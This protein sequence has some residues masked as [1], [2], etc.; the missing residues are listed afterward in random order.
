MNN[1]WHSRREILTAG[2]AVTGAALAGCLG[3][4]AS[5]ETDRSEQPTETVTEDG[6]IQTPDGSEEPAGGSE[7]AGSA[8]GDAPSW[9]D[10]HNMRFRGWYNADE[11][12]PSAPYHEQNVML[13]V[14]NR[15]AYVIETILIDSDDRKF[16]G[17]QRPMGGP[18]SGTVFHERYFWFNSPSKLYRENPIV[19]AEIRVVG[20]AQNER[21]RIDLTEGEHHEVWFS[22]AVLTAGYWIGRW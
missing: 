7:L 6:N 21:L 19:A 13:S 17:N 12:D 20:S 18:G 10:A 2:A 11:Y 1:R 8:G 3:A 14:I 4:P 16:P 9:V 15:G 5:S 22:G